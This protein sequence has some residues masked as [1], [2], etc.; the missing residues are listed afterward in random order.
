MYVPSRTPTP[1][2]STLVQVPAADEF[3]HI[4]ETEPCGA[5]QNHTSDRNLEG[6]RSFRGAVCSALET[7]LGTRILSPTCSTTKQSKILTRSTM[8]PIHRRIR[9]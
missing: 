7:N 2:T 5:R 6:Y 8:L 4:V 9:Q 1:E 3:R